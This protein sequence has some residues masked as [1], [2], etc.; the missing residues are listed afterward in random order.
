MRAPPAP[1]HPRACR[2]P[3]VRG[4]AAARDREAAGAVDRQAALLADAAPQVREG[5]GPR[6]AGG[7]C[8]ALLLLLCVLLPAQQPDAF[9]A[10]LDGLAP[11]AAPAPPRSSRVKLFVN[12]ETAE[13]I[14]S[15]GAHMC[16]MDGFVAFHNSH[17]IRWAGSEWA[18]RAGWAG[19]AKARDGE[20][21]VMPA[22]NGPLVQAGGAGKLRMRACN[23]LL[24]GA[25][26][27]AR[28]RPPA[29]GGWA[30]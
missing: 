23:Q 3:A 24:A 18:G 28:A 5:P 4:A 16:P 20:G 15:R 30:R 27:A 2:Q 29:A 1:M 25:D 21:Q 13:K 11:P 9:E 26:A 17:L 8:S 7:A 14:Y 10:G 22:S 19:W 12:L 6:P